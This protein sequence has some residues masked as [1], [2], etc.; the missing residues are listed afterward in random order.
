MIYILKEKQIIILSVVISILSIIISVYS[1]DNMIS[2]T[3]KISEIEIKD[4]NNTFEPTFSH[5]PMDAVQ[6][7]INP[8]LILPPLEEY[9]NGIKCDNSCIHG[10]CAEIMVGTARGG[11]SNP[12]VVC[13]TRDGNGPVKCWIHKDVELIRD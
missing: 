7:K 3:T 6:K 13:D 2:Q 8:L 12:M 4:H 5:V 10:V 9:C 1:V 11:F